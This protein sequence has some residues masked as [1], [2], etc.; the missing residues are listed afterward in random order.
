M[1]AGDCYE[2]IDT[3]SAVCN[4]A[5][6]CSYGI[7]AVDGYPNCRSNGK[8]LLPHVNACPFLASGVKRNASHIINIRL[9]TSSGQM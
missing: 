8:G 9:L 5:Y 2:L 1:I 3:N 7:G 6:A 4:T